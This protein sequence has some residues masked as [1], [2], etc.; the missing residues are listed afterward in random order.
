MKFKISKDEG[1]RLTTVEFSWTDAEMEHL[2]FNEI[3]RS[4]FNLPVNLP[5][6]ASMVVSM[7]AKALE[8]ADRQAKRVLN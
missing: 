8:E 7:I 4:V 1:K 6:E 2:E 5:S 3:E